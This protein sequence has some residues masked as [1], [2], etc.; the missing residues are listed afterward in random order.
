MVSLVQKCLKKPGVVTLSEYSKLMVGVNSGL[1][2][3][4]LCSGQ[5]IELV[6]FYTL[7]YAIHITAASAS[8]SAPACYSWLA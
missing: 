2:L 3:W 5:H 7:N 6:E 8:Q 1:T 4:P